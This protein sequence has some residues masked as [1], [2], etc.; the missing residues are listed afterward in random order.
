MPAVARP[1]GSTCETTVYPRAPLRF[2]GGYTLAARF[3]GVAAEAA[4]FY[5]LLNHLSP[6]LFVGFF[7]RRYDWIAFSHLAA[8]GVSKFLKEELSVLLQHLTAFG[9]FGCSHP[10]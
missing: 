2:A 5:A 3:A 6:S 10:C 9:L 1:A 8:I 4:S 7:L